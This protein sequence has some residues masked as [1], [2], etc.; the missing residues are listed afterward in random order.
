MIRHSLF[1]NGDICGNW[2]R[3]TSVT[4]E[5]VG[6]TDTLMV[7]WREEEKGK[8]IQPTTARMKEYPGARVSE[9]PLAVVVFVVDLEDKVMRESARFVL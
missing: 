8:K 3:P 7:N 2:G 4:N 9:P 1:R 6:G 5:Q